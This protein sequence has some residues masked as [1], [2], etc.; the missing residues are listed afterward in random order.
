M[1]LGYNLML[2]E[3][4]GNITLPVSIC[5]NPQIVER[6]ILKFKVLCTLQIGAKKKKKKNHVSALTEQEIT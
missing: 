4:H 5:K 1:L 3:L 2:N 6:V